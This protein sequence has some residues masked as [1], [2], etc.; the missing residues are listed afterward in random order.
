M[1][2]GIT[3]AGKIP[4]SQTAEAKV[5]DS[6]SLVC[7]LLNCLL[8]SVPPVTQLWGVPPARSPPTSPHTR[9]LSCP[10]FLSHP[11]PIPRSLN[12]AFLRAPS[13]PCANLQDSVDLGGSLPHPHQTLPPLRLLQQPPLSTHYSPG[14]DLRF[15]DVIQTCYRGGAYHVAG[16]E[17]PQSPCCVHVGGRPCVPRPGHSPSDAF[18]KCLWTNT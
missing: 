14:P 16:G 8:I 4:R 9:T 3:A 5:W 1:G 10:C 6:F 12:T 17:R 2:F 11:S 7:M 18:G 15:P 13:L